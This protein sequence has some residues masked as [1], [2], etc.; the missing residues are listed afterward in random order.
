MAGRQL[1]SARGS[2]SRHAVSL[3]IAYVHDHPFAV[4]CFQGV[5][6]EHAAVYTGITLG[7][8]RDSGIGHI[9]VEGHRSGSDVEGI[10]IET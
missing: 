8:K 4:S 6:H 7:M 2:L 5:F 3:R 9:L 1:L 10:E